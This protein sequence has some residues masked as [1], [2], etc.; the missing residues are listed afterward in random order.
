D[1]PGDGPIYYII[2]S[3]VS[4]LF[5]AL[6]V[7]CDGSLVN[8]SLEGMGVDQSKVTLPLDATTLSAGAVLFSALFWG[9]VFFDLIGATHLFPF[10]KK[11][12]VFW[13]R[14]FI[15]VSVL[16]AGLG[17]TIVVALGWWRAHSLLTVPEVQAAMVDTGTVGGGS[18]LEVA[19]ENGVD[20]GEIETGGCPAVLPD[21]RDLSPSPLEARVIHLVLEG[22][23]FLS[24]ISSAFC[25]VGALVFVKFF[26]LLVVVMVSTVLLWPLFCV[27]S[28]LTLVIN[29]I[30]VFVTAALDWLIGFGEMLLGLFNWQPPS[31]EA[32]SG[33]VVESEPANE[34]VDAAVEV[35]S[36]GGNGQGSD[37]L[38]DD[39]GFNPFARR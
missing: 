28:L 27:S 8:L 29:G 38:D 23:P 35:T 24:Y 12:S 20:L 13:R 26:I 5:S 15:G 31:A 11:L 19:G 18:G 4:V 25:C 3:I 17:L 32:A 2:G 39:P 1:R 10:R 21:D 6:F 14:L 7:L 36:A 34:P 16:M 22:I 37:S 30:A 33:S 9:M